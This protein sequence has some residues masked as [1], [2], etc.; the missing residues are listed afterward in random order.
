MFTEYSAIIENANNLKHF[1]K[2]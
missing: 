1:F 2:S